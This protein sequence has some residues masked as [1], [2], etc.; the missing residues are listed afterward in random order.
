MTITWNLLV[1]SESTDSEEQDNKSPETTGQTEY[2]SR[3]A[4]KYPDVPSV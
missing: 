1:R 4:T 3:H 2:K